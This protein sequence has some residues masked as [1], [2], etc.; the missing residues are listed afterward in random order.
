MITETTSTDLQNDCLGENNLK[1]ILNIFLTK[2]SL[3]AMFILCAKKGILVAKSCLCQMLRL[4]KE[5]LTKS[6]N[7]SCSQLIWSDVK[8]TG[9]VSYASANL[10][11]SLGSDETQICQ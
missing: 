4:S 6:F 11:K 8:P 9:D 10:V 1:N 5:K 3:T 7:W 2:I